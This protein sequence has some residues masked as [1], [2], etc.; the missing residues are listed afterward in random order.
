MPFRRSAAKQSRGMQ[1]G[2]RARTDARNI[3]QVL[4][5]PDSMRGPVANDSAGTDGTNP[6]K[7]TKFGHAGGFEV[8]PPR[9][10][11]RHAARLGPGDPR[12]PGPEGGNRYHREQSVRISHTVHVIISPASAGAS[13]GPAANG[14]AFGARAASAARAWNA[15]PP[16]AGRT[17]A[18]ASPRDRRN[19][20]RRMIR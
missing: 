8:D 11:R 16:S 14:I 10:L 6:G 12:P 18:A 17:T 3:H 4:N 19:P 15:P 1:A 13:R 5:A 2:N 7:Q 20:T 9:M